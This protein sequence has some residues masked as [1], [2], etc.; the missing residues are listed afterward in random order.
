[1]DAKLQSR[2]E[3][4]KGLYFHCEKYSMGH[5]CKNKKLE[6]ILFQ[7]EGEDGTCTQRVTEKLSTNLV[8]G[9]PD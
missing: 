1:M 8:V 6:I 3:K 2:E 4:E 7:E 9:M 5:R